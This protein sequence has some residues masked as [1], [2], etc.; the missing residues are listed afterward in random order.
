MKKIIFLSLLSTSALAADF[1]CSYFQNLQEIHRSQ[2]SV[3][4]KNVRIATFDQYE[5]FMSQLPEGRFEL[6]AYNSYEPSR[7][8]AVARLSS[9][10]PEI[11]LTIWKREIMIEARCTLKSH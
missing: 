5:F 11:E 8:Y 2:V 1:E 9:A 3:T 6:Q 4:G 10:N 7:T